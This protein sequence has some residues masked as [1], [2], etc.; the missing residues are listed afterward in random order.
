MAVLRVDLGER[1]GET[2][3]LDKDKTIFGRERDCDQVIS[4]EEVVSRHHAQIR[5]DG[6][7]WLLQDLKSRNGTKLNGVEIP[8]G[9]DVPLN[10]KDVI[11]I[12]EEF[13]ATFFDVGKDEEVAGTSTIE[14]MLSSSTDHNLKTQPAAKLAALLDITAKL[15]KTLELDA[16]LPEVAD[17]LLKIFTQADRC[18]IILVDED[19]GALVPKVIRTRLHVAESSKGFSRTI[20]LQCLKSGQALL[21]RE[22]DS[23]ARNSESVSAFHIRSVMCVPLSTAEGKSSV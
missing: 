2:I 10:H 14:A 5:R 1:L 4:R 22:G 6:K 7:S 9:I 8:K 16:Q 18:F 15:S 13:Q 20:I 17:G 19:N 21:L 11:A 3:E 12:C 23:L